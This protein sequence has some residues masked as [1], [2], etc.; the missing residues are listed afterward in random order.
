MIAGEKNTRRILENL[1]LE[2]IK[3]MVPATWVMRIK[4]ILR[5]SFIRFLILG[6]TPNK[7]KARC[8][9]FAF[10]SENIN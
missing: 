6:T 10:F 9:N 2:Q 8:E 3:S 7:Q 1:S 4:R 5:H